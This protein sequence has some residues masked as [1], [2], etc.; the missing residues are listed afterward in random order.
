MRTG[1]QSNN[2]KQ[3]YVIIFHQYRDE[4][5]I[6]GNEKKKKMNWEN[7]ERNFLKMTESSLNKLLMKKRDRDN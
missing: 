3:S 4:K 7:A 2:G 6:I 5:S 1:T